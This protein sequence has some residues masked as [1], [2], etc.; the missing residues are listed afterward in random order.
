M[1]APVVEHPA[2]PS[3][4]A[5][6]PLRAPLRRPAFRRLASA[7]VLN[8]LGN[9]LGEIALVVV[10][11]DATSSALATTALFLAAR[12]APGLL[13]P[14]F[15]AR[16]HGRLALSAIYL[17]EAVLT[18]ALAILASHFS[19]PLV[20]LLAAIDGVLAATA[21]TFARAAVAALL[22]PAD[23]LRAGNAVLNVGYTAAA[24]LGPA[25][26]GLLVALLGAPFALF[27]DALSFLLVALAVARVHLAPIQGRGSV[28]GALSYVRRR[29]GLRLLLLGQ[30]LVTVFLTLVLPIEVV[31]AKSTLHAGDQGFGALLAAWGVGMALGGVLFTRLRQRSLWPLILFATAA[32]GVS[33]LT[34]AI[35]ASLAVACAAAAIGGTG[36][37]VQWVALISA[38]QELAQGPFEARVLA[39]FEAIASAMPGIGFLLGGLLTA[40]A[41]PRL[42]YAV[43][44]LGALTL[45]AIGSAMSQNGS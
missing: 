24:A 12:F 3:G 35:A 20:L 22:A 31:F 34:T 45:A 19:F 16:L 17:S 9:W 27:L 29:P 25:L 15:V 14:A 32:M 8:E 40:A 26:A 28:R 39:L 38:V 6:A 11:F 10:V 4:A 44:G 42:A 43:A 21:R 23:E 37:G 13:A 7:Y 30:A 2:G 36:N 41:G 33:Y 5:H 18:G 1:S